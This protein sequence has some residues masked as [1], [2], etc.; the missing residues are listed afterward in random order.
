MAGLGSRDTYPNKSHPANNPQRHIH[1]KTLVQGNSSTTWRG[2]NNS[3]GIIFIHMFLLLTVLLLL[4]LLLS[5]A[6]SAWLK[7]VG[8]SNSP[9]II[10]I[11]LRNEW[12]SR[13]STVNNSGM[14][15][16]SSMYSTI[17]SSLQLLL[18]HQQITV[19]LCFDN[20]LSKR[21]PPLEWKTTTM[22]IT[23]SLHTHNNSR[24]R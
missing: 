18:Y 2:I 13:H 11:L 12:S 17:S 6:S 7:R 3:D 9:F 22:M 20:P 21:L 19:N 1:G 8:W 5:P 16:H 24:N 4:L 10:P 15:T 14:N 23:S